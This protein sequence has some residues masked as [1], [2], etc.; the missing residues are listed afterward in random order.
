MR[1]VAATLPA[2]PAEPG[3]CGGSDERRKRSD[4]KDRTRGKESDGVRKEK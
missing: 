4:K 3:R 1:G 2:V